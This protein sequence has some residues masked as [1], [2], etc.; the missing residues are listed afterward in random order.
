MNLGTKANP[1]Y[2]KVNAQLPKEKIEDLKMLLKEFKYVFAWTYKDLKNIP[3]KLVQHIIEL[4]TSIPLARY[5]LN[6][7]YIEA[8]KQY[9]DK[10]L[11][12]GFIQPIDE[13]TWLSPIMVVFNKNKIKNLCGF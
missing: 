4:D 7:N 11:A 6:L 2:I 3:P 12:V 5:Q 10:L 8:V 1:Q 13:A 9:I